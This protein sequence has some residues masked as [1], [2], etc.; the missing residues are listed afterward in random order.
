MKVN[1][2]KMAAYLKKIHGSTCPL[3]NSN[4][5]TISD[6]V[7]QTP[8]FDYKGLLIGGASYP[9]VPLTCQVCGNTYFINAL[10]SGLIEKEP[11]TSSSKPNNSSENNNEK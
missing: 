8:E 4:A 9:V 7:F 3:C 11:P 1:Q 2:E 6:Q 5:W 10:V